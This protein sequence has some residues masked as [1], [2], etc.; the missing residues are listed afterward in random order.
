MLQAVR[1]A[2][3][4]NVLCKSY[5][6]RLLHLD[7]TAR[8]IILS[9][10]DIEEGKFKGEELPDSLLGL[11]DPKILYSSYVKDSIAKVDPKILHSIAR[12]VKLEEKQRIREHAMPL[13]IQ[14]NIVK[15]ESYSEL[16]SQSNKELKVFYPYAHVEQIDI[17]KSNLECSDS[18]DFL[19]PQ[20]S[21]QEEIALRMDA[22]EDGVLEQLD[23]PKGN[24]VKD[25][26][27]NDLNA[28][29]LLED[30]DS[31]LQLLIEQQG[32]ADPDYPV[33]NVP[34]GGCGAHLHCQQP[35]LIG[36]IPK[37]LFEERDDGELRNLL[38]QRCYFMRFHKTALNVRVDPKMYTKL[39]EPIKM[40]RALVLLVVDLLDVPCS[41]WPK[42]MDIIGTQKPV[43][44]VGNKV[45]LL[46]ADGINHLRRVKHS[47]IR[48][49]EKTPLSQS[50]IKHVAL[51]S[52]HT[53]YGIES[54]ITHIQGSWATKGNIYIVGCTNSGK[55]TLFN[56]LL[57]SDLCKTTASSLIRRATVSPWPGTTL[58]MLKFPILRPSGQMLH[59]RTQRLKEQRKM[60][61][62]GGKPKYTKNILI[63]TLSGHIGRT[64]EKKE[65][66]LEKEDPFSTNMRKLPT[67]EP[68]PI[69]GINPSHEQYS[70]SKWCYDTPGTV[71]PEQL[72]NLLTHDELMKVLP[73]Q[74][75][76][77]RTFCLQPG[78]SIF[79]AGLAR[80]DL[81]YSPKSVRFTVFRSEWLP[82][83][84]T[85]TVDAASTYSR[86]LGSSLLGVPSEGEERL[87]CWPPLQPVN[88]RTHC[89]NKLESCAD[90]VLS[91][92]GWVSL[93]GFTEQQVIELRAWTPGG[94]GIHL[95]D[96]PLLPLA[97]NL[98]GRRI[99]K[100]LAH[101][102]HKIFEIG[103][104]H[105]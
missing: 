10:H 1:Q 46:P 72:I 69:M 33:S 89:H 37:E 80:L 17:P 47:L 86:Y 94:R 79:L 43:V 40:K 27:N 9:Q 51:V 64:L 52:A 29:S 5:C 88:L 83:T 11:T 58:G 15:S 19:K 97:V 68:K 77:P 75:L 61:P 44:V 50:F 90:V 35:S 82:L 73:R 7:K 96:P 26:C 60:Q 93:T 41:I 55:S 66:M 56:A 98:R 45:D 36:F 31:Q 25:Q 53:G 6:L 62:D 28:D 67:E 22:Y 12:R 13:I 20:L 103:R 105:V 34:C 3:V 38:C 16:N 2:P 71:Q 4:L 70:L 59:L 99:G 92:A 23:E 91:S 102:P 18:E 39:L 30:E 65:D 21:V 48:A 54:L 49:I 42:I 95:R 57:G 81:L 104:A 63:G 32:S 100:S 87:K 84:I 85:K 78:H 24:L 101:R 8:H 14:K 76:R 74:L